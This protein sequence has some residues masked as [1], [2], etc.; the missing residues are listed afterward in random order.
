LVAVK[1]APKV[2]LAE[3]PRSKLREFVEI[4]RCGVSDRVRPKEI[5]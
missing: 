1:G 3:L 2:A 4:R 5:S